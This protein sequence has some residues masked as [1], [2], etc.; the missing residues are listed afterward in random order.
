MLAFQTTLKALFPDA[1]GRRNEERAIPQLLIKYVNN[2]F[3]VVLHEGTNHNY[4]VT[5]QARVYSYAII[6][7]RLLSK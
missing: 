1:A 3:L 6:Y 7:V 2:L 4:S 5:M